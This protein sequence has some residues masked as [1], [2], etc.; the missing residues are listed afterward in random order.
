M[1]KQWVSLNEK[2]RGGNGY[3]VFSHSI[4]FA[5]YSCFMMCVVT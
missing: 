2:T 5:T 1:Q 4:F 3:L